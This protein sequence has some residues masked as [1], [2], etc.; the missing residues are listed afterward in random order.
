MQQGS[1]SDLRQTE[2]FLWDMSDMIERAE[3]LMAA[4]EMP[5]FNPG[6]LDFGPCGT[7]LCPSDNFSYDGR[8]S[9]DT[10]AGYIQVSAASEWVGKPVS[11]RLG[12]R[13][14]QTDV[15]STV[16]YPQYTGLVWVSGNEMAP[17]NNGEQIFEAAGSR[18][19]GR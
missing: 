7:A 8:T 6:N 9:E 12:L 13:Y 4:G 14:E 2:F 17:T 5:I 16:F 10:T 15:K 11:M 19:A 18:L 1:N 3:T